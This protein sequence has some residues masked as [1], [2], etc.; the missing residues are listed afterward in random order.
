MPRLNASAYAE[1]KRRVL[2]RDRWQCQSCGQRTQLDVHHIQ[3]RSQQG[4]DSE[5]NLITLCRQCHR[6][7]HSH[8]DC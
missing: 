1:L 3:F 2:E 4:E 6:R 8:E 7:V 5:L